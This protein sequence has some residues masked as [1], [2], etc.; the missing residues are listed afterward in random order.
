MPKIYSSYVKICERSQ[1]V[2]AQKFS[3]VTRAVVFGSST[4][5]CDRKDA[6]Y[7][8]RIYHLQKSGSR[9]IA[10]SLSQVRTSRL[11][12]PSERG[13]V[14]CKYVNIKLL[15]VILISATCGMYIDRYFSFYD[16]NLRKLDDITKTPPIHKG[17]RHHEHDPDY[18]ACDPRNFLVLVMSGAK[19]TYQKRRR[20]WR[21]G[22]CP[23]SY[24]AHNITYRFILAMPAHET[25]DPNSHNQGKVASSIEISDMAVLRDEYRDHGDVVFLSMK[26][27]YEDLSLKTLRGIE[28][29]VDRGMTHDTSI[30]VKHDD[31]YCLRTEVLRGIC[32]NSTGPDLVS[33]R[34]RTCGP[35][36]VMKVKRASTGCSCH[37]SPDLCTL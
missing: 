36:R 23:A 20:I 32:L 21:D 6:M 7:V 34:G 35:A 27:V 5:S 19:A 12:C 15:I 17:P 13:I 14:D 11:M 24:A 30:V 25:I 4:G 16:H 3:I 8:A 26:D 2:L 29:A 18:D 22:P 10:P 37:V 28:W 31:E 33:M 1:K 9:S